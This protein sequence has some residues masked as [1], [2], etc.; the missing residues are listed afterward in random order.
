MADKKIIFT[1][2]M[3]YDSV[4]PVTYEKGSVHALRED[5]ADR[6][7]KRGVATEDLASATDAE[8]PAGSSSRIPDDW[9]SLTA[10]ETVALAVSL[11]ADAEAVRFKAQAV[12]F[13]EGKIAER[14]AALA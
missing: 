3:R 9:R 12:A 14:A 10:A 5:L 8:Q 6:W 4:P 1:A 2:T 7:I 11:G 13:I